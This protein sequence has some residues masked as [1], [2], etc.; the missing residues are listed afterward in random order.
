MTITMHILQ[1]ERCDSRQSLLWS[2]VGSGGSF[3]FKSKLIGLCEKRFPDTDLGV[4][5]VCLVKVVVELVRLVIILIELRQE[6]ILQ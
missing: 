1:L 2:A 3:N 4:R 6:N 5:K